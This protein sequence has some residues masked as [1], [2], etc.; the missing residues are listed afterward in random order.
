MY[1]SSLNLD[2]KIYWGGCRGL[3]V[4]RAFDY[5]GTA[6]GHLVSEGFVLY[7]DYGDGL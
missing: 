7:P 3:G 6:Q 5:K 4:R 2:I 1:A